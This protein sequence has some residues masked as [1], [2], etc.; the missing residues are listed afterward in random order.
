MTVAEKIQRDFLEAYRTKDKKRAGVLS[1]LRAALKNEEINQMRKA[2]DDEAVLQVVR[3]ELKKSRESLS[4]WEK[5]KRDDQAIEERQAITILDQYLPK[6]IDD[7]I[8]KNELKKLIKEM[9]LE[10]IQD[11]GKI[12]GRAM[13]ELAGRASGERVS[14][15]V[16]GL[17]K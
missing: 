10:S 8:L 14:Q 3:R 11:F 9:A 12:M 5:A 2:L 15:M 4:E 7:E 13:K 16:K 1:M 6:E 17:L